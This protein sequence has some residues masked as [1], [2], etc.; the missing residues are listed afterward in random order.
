MLE[1]KICR[2]W[3]AAILK[4][5]DL[6]I[7]AW[8]VHAIMAPTAA[9]KVIP[10]RCSPVARV[11]DRRWFSVTTAR[12]CLSR[13]RRNA[14]AKTFSRSSIP[15]IPGV[16]T[17]YFLRAAVNRSAR[18]SWRSRA[19][20]RGVLKP[21]REKLTASWLDESSPRPVNE[22]FSGGEKRGNLQMAFARP[23][24]VLDE[25]IQASIS[26][27]SKLSPAE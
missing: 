13:I 10:F 20:R 9:A 24:S 8:E 16:N 4:G 1:I 23:V 5:I 18:A 15:E 27:R 26:M 11:R 25:R 6:S 14:C 12:I 19:E 17:T 3:R 2:R 21:M 7:N 22:G